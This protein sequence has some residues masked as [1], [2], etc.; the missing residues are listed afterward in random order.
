MIKIE[1]GWTRVPGKENTF[2]YTTSHT[3]ALLQDYQ[4]IIKIEF[5]VTT[6]EFTVPEGE[7]PE[8]GDFINNGVLVKR[9]GNQVN[10][11]WRMW[12]DK[13]LYGNP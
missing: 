10:P 1:H 5:D 2:H 13:D 8:I 11:D 4:S 7:Q 3:D 12:K 9:Q 6:L